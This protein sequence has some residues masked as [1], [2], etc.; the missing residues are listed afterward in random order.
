MKLSVNGVS[1]IF[2]LA[3]WAS[4][5]FTQINELITELLSTFIVKNTMYNRK[6]MDSKLIEIAS[7]RA[8]RHLSFVV[9]NRIW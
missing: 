2:G 5:G 1:T 7:S 3:Y 6:N 4:H 9:E 8:C